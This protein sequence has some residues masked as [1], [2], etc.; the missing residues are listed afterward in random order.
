[1]KPQPR[2][3]DRFNGMSWD[4]ARKELDHNAHMLV[5]EVKNDL[6]S[7]HVAEAYRDY[8]IEVGMAT[9]VAI[10]FIRK[11]GASTAALKAIEI[12]KDVSKKVKADKGLAVKLKDRIAKLDF[13]LNQMENFIYYA[14]PRR[15]VKWVLEPEYEKES[16]IRHRAGQ[17]NVM[18]FYSMLELEAGN[19]CGKV[20]ALG[21]Q[22]FMDEMIKDSKG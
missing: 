7:T 6:Y 11:H 19:T 17:A 9:L 22:R 10:L 4:R 8:G 12:Y 13:E 20:A 5:L 1:M 2:G 14:S 21:I 3:L 18:L 15:D 16:A